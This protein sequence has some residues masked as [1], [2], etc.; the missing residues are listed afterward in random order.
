M[1]IVEVVG[2]RQD[3]LRE[4]LWKVWHGRF[5]SMQCLGASP[6]LLLVLARVFLVNPA[7]PAAHVRPYTERCIEQ[8][9]YCLFMVFLLT[10]EDVAGL[11]KHTSFF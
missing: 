3:L 9:Y 7:N 2:L 8:R 4:F 1:V 11:P 6:W 5:S 10:I